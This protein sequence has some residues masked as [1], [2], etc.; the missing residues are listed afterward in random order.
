[1][2]DPAHAPLTFEATSAAD[3]QLA[4]RSACPVAGADLMLVHGMASSGRYWGT[5]LGPLAERYR[6]V[7]PDLLGFGRSPKPQDSSYSPSE[8]AAMLARVAEAAGAPLVV[9]GHSLGALLA[10]HFAVRYP[11]LVRG[12]VLLSMPFFATEAEAR[13]QLARSSAMARLQIRHP[14]AARL[15]CELMCHARPLVATLMPA[16]EREVEPDAARDAVRHTWRS[17]SRTVEQVILQ[18]R[19]VE[20][21]DRLP[22]ERLLF[23]HAADDPTAPVDN[24]AAYVRARPAVEFVQLPGGGHHPYLRQPRQT[25]QAISAFVERVTRL[26]G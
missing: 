13:E 4:V 3:D 16:L 19:P 2:Q 9:V 14:R 17:A 20:L 21:L 22:A 6:V 23:V 12:A 10:L 8:H 11:H 15:V 18:T 25:C 26:A 7:A 24:V 1:M 5:N